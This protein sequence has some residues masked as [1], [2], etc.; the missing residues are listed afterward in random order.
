MFNLGDRTVD[1]TAPAGRRVVETVNLEA[2]S[3]GAVPPMAGL[4]LSDAA[5]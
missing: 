1:W 2:G 5:G 4:V 3:G